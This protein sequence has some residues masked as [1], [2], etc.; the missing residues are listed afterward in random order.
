MMLHDMGMEKKPITGRFLRWFLVQASFPV[1]IVGAGLVPLSAGAQSV[2]QQ[3]LLTLDEA[4][5]RTLAQHPELDVFVNKREAFRGVVDQ[6]G[7]GQRPDIGL[8]VEDFGGTGDYDAVD[9]T[10][11]TLSI[12]WITQG[13]RIESRVQAARV[14][15]SQVE[16]QKEIKALDLS[17][18]TSRL[19]IQ[20]LVEEQRLA[21]SHTAAQ[22]ARD[23]VAAIKMRVAIGKSPEFEH[24]Q[25]EVELAQRELEAEDLK[26]RLASTRYRLRAQWGEEGSDFRLVGALQKVPKLD[27][28]EQQFDQLKENP[29]LAL[30]ATQQRIAE[31]KIELARIEARPQWQFSLGVRRF[32]TTDD[33]GLVA[34]LSVPLGRDRKS[35]GK[36][37]SLQGEQ[38]AYAS[39]FEA[40]QRQLTTQLYV[41]LQEISHSQHV[42]RT[43]QEQ[44]LPALQKAEAHAGRAYESGKL[45]YQQWTAILHKRLV[46]QQELLSALEA[47]HLQH[48]ELQ[49]LTGSTLN[50]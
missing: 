39:E 44:I 12:S 19:F 18:Q 35:A 40:F 6:A 32:E 11:S 47:I 46:A 10:Q 33:V 1:L 49:R 22:Q 25:A 21:L 50:F 38:A 31:S 4:V 26:H 20:A 9:R 13:A 15:A 14:A 27:S 7:V 17:A 28:A 42:I 24:L 36:V 29:A 34:G 37:R 23:T 41:L 8:M 48:I 5:Q 16:V 2:S 30:L 45:G 3:P 43:L